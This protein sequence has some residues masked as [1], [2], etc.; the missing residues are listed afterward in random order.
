MERKES[1]WERKEKILFSYKEIKMRIALCDRNKMFL[2]N[3]KSI[4][5]RYCESRRLDVVIDCYCKGE[6]MLASG[7]RYNVAFLNYTLCGE[8][9]LEIAKILRREYYNTAIIFMSSNQDFVF[10]AFKVNPYRFLL[11][12]I[13]SED[14]FIVMDEFFEEYGKDYP[15]WIKSRDSVFCLNT[16]DI[17]YLEADNKHCFIHL[18]EEK[19]PCNRTMARVFE[20]LP[21][22]SF[23]KINRAFII[24]LNFITGYNSDLVFLKNGE[25]LHISRKYFKSFKQGYFE[26]LNPRMP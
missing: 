18:K 15:L 25:K 13:K 8:N 26:Y 17:Y 24:N 1:I 4:L 5:Y 7:L 19:L 9:G 2:K 10:D 14:L 11:K 6:D 20:V 22:Y 12:P 23:L 3:L 21:K 16:G